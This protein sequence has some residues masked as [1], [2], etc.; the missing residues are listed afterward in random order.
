MRI[1]VAAVYLLDLLLQWPHREAFYCDTGMLPRTLMASSQHSLQWSLYYGWGGLGPITCLFLL[2]MGCVLAL[3]LG[4]RTRWSSLACFFMAMSLQNRVE[5]LPGWDGELRLLF[6]YGFFLPWGERFS[7]DSRRRRVG[8]QEPAWSLATLAWRVQLMSLYVGAGLLKGGPYWREG[9]AVE[10]SLQSDAYA[11]YWGQKL[12][13]VLKPFPEALVWLND[14]VPLFEMFTPVLL[15]TP[16]PWVQLLGALLLSGMHLGF[17]LC[18]DIDL[19]SPVCIACLV[20]FLPGSLWDFLSQ[21]WPALGAQG[22]PWQDTLGLASRV[23]LSW[24]SMV[25]IWAGLSGLP[26]GRGWMTSNARQPL[27]LF[28]LEQRWGMFV[29]PPTRGG[30]HVVRGRTRGGEWVD[31]LHRR[32]HLDESKPEWIHATYPTVRHYLHFANY[33]RD[34]RD[35]RGLR[36][37]AANFYKRYWEQAF[38]ERVDE[39]RR[40][41]ILHYRR[42]YTPGRGY[43]A[44]Q[45]RLIWAQET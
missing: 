42:D 18:L 28:G 10:V 12:I 34:G 36:Q 45:R 11:T 39:I 2:Q 4:W 21:K 35:G 3:L 41:E 44:V 23:F 17:G 26:E 24:I 43:S 9:T 33:L 15:C 27:R 40:V 30:W 5:V 32:R 19:F 29:P 20:C 7:L 8:A 13:E 16:W 37:A 31:L 14:G 25:V 38:G 1:A 22:E 6:L